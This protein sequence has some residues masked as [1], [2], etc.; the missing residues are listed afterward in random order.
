MHSITSGIIVVQGWTYQNRLP[1]GTDRFIHK[2]RLSGVAVIG[3]GPRPLFGYRVVDDFGA[4][5]K[6]LEVAFVRPLFE[7][8]YSSPDAGILVGTSVFSSASAT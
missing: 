7:I 3:M 2:L 4:D 5:A 6:L 8:D 1:K